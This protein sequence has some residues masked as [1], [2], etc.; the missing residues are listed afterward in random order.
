MF[1]GTGSAWLHQ[2][3]DPETYRRF[4]AA[5]EEWDAYAAPQLEVPFDQLADDLPP[6]AVGEVIADVTAQIRA[7]ARR[8]RHGGEHRAWQLPPMA[9]AC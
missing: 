5:T 2:L 3:T 9:V 6:L 1:A 8:L 4:V 7:C